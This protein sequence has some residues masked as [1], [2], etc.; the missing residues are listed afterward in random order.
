MNFKAESEL[1]EDTQ[2]ISHNQPV[3]KQFLHTPGQRAQ[4][5][6]QEGESK[7]MTSIDSKRKRSPPSYTKPVKKLKVDSDTSDTEEND[8]IFIFTIC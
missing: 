7:C 3:I 4:I 2:S 5:P 6:V 8:I 1:K